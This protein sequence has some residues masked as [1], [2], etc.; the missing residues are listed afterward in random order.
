MKKTLTVGDL[1]KYLETLNDNQPV[2]V[3]TRYGKV[4][5]GII[6]EGLDENRECVILDVVYNR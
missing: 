2:V 4:S 1:K 5:V 3:Q 6:R